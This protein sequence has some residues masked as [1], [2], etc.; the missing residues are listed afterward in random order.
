M[1]GEVPFCKSEGKRISK[2]TTEIQGDASTVVLKCCLMDND[3]KFT[4]HNI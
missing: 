1:F 2:S 3:F 4:K